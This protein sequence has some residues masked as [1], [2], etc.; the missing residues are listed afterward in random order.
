MRALVRFSVLSRHMTV[1]TETPRRSR[2]HRQWDL[3]DFALTP[4][5]HYLQRREFLR[6]C[7]LG[8]AGSALLPLHR[9]RMA[10][11]ERIEMNWFD[12][13]GERRA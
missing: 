10:L 6:V 3:P 7:G 11:R 5:A 1:D 2:A 4:E 13:V 8:F 12:P 9:A